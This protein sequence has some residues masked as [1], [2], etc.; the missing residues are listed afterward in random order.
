MV[1]EAVSILQLHNISCMH[2]T[3]MH[4]HTLIHSDHDTHMHM[5]MHTYIYIR[6][7]THTDA[8]VYTHT[9]TPHSFPH[10]HT[11]ICTHRHAHTYTRTCTHI[12]IRMHTH[13][14]ADTHT[15]THTHTHTQTPTTQLS[16]HVHL[17]SLHNYDIPTKRKHNNSISTVHW[18]QCSDSARWCH[19]PNSFHGNPGWVYP[20][21]GTKMGVHWSQVRI[22]QQGNGVAHQWEASGNKVPC[23]AGRVGAVRE[24]GNLATAP[25]SAHKQRNT[26]LQR[27]LQD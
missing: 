19:Y 3:H 2:T 7:H 6:M 17:H 12:C 24:G 27:R 22:G 20:W 4:W 26:A 23:Y 16:T 25:Q 14:D 15:H 11:Y 13:T 1:S 9:H 5:H 21:N 10:M 18:Y 8:D